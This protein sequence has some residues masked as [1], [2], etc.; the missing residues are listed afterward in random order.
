MYKKTGSLYLINIDEYLNKNYACLTFYFLLTD[1][2]NEFLST[3]D[4]PLKS[5]YMQHAFL[6]INSL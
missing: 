5:V 6:D 2:V 3:K 4:C 1:E